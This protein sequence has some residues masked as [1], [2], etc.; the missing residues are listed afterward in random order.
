[1]RLNS[2]VQSGLS[3]SSRISPS[4]IVRWA[5]AVLGSRQ[6]RWVTVR[7]IVCRLPWTGSWTGGSN[8]LSAASAISAIT[9]VI[10]AA[11]AHCARGRTSHNPSVVV[12]APPAPPATIQPAPR[13]SSARTDDGPAA[14]GPRPWP[15]QSRAPRT[16]CITTPPGRGDIN[17]GVMPETDH[18]PGQSS[19][20]DD[21]GARQ[22]G[23]GLIRPAQQ[24]ASHVLRRCSPGSAVRVHAST[25]RGRSRASQQSQGHAKAKRSNPAFF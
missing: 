7:D 1:M 23:C 11:R 8:N 24:L 2:A 3:T 18:Q 25:V 16:R 9:R 21:D 10:R 20:L 5:I 6:L 14:A 13:L 17:A 12:R 4:Q 22:D 15:P 19:D